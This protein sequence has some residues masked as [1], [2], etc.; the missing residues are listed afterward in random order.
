M[1]TFLNICLWKCNNWKRK[2]NFKDTQLKDLKFSKISNYT[3]LVLIR[4][5]L[6]EITT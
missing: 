5:H 2:G 3:S 4:E 1:L 6:N